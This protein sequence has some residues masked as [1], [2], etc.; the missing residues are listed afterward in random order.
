MKLSIYIAAIA[1]CAPL[2]THAQTQAPLA[3]DS[4]NGKVFLSVA[5][6]TAQIWRRDDA[7]STGAAIPVA[8]EHEGLPSAWHLSIQGTQ[9]TL[10]VQ[11]SSCQTSGGQFPMSFVLLTNQQLTHGCCTV[12]E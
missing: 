3:C 7:R 1:L 10:I 8:Q 12:A 5:G 11:E 6:S 4:V 2:A 9:A